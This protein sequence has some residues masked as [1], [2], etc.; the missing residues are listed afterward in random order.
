MKRLALF[1]R[2][3]VP[4]DPWQLIFLLGVVLLF[5]SPRLSW[6]PSKLLE[7]AGPAVGP[8]Q[9]GAG[10]LESGQFIFACLY[11]VMFAGIAGYFVCFW[12]GKT[13]VRR[14][15]LEVCLPTILSLVLVLWMFF[16]ISQT[17]PSIFESRG[18]LAFII[19][20]FQLS[21]SKFPLGLYFC[22]FGL[23]LI[24]FY[25]S[26]LALGATSLQ[27]ALSNVQAPSDGGPDPWPSVR[28][29]VFLLV[30]PYYLLGGLV[31][32]LLLGIPY[33]ASP[34]LSH[35]FWTVST[36]IATV[37]DAVVF[38]GIS[39]YILGKKGRDSARIALRLPEPRFAFA[40]L[41]MP[42]AI[43]GLIP[44]GHFLFDRVHWAT[45]DFGK[46]GPPHLS[47]YFD[48]AS[49]WQPWLFFMVFIAVAEEI[50]FRGLLLPRFIGRYGLQRGLFL[51]GII[52]AAFHFRSDSYS[53]L[54]VGGVLLHLANRV[55]I[56]LAM[57]YV[58]V[59]MT[60]RWNSIFPGA[61]AHATWNFLA[62]ILMDTRNIWD[63]ELRVALWA[64]LAYFLFRF[65]PLVDR[66][67]PQAAQP[68][69]SPEPAV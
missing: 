7:S 69:P 52:W 54:S 33:I 63:S 45:Y 1:L 49:S 50:V 34:R 4:A 27:F 51:T 65:W 10:H 62:A 28:L 30:G 43:S 3:V 20:W 41:V 35:T 23:A 8:F 66:E 58:F 18:N 22:A 38:V 40:G 12:P 53:G 13:P 25:L 26:R 57:N 6:W 14:I 56:C 31:A 60:L 37:L 64:V 21:D 19:K 29:L 48:F 15:L 46:F 47:T 68:E 16:K 24:L 17:A 59:W 42:V 11:P 36:N 67:T 55:L 61:I 39:L 5:I 2:S 32:L 44:P 9:S